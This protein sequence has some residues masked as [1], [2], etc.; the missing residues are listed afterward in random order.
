MKYLCNWLT[1]RD[2]FLLPQVIASLRRELQNVGQ[3]MATAKETAAVETKEREKLQL[4]LEA[5]R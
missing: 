3:E 4:E 2:A 1:P 5:L